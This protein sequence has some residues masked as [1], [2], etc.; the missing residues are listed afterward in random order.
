MEVIKIKLLNIKIL[1]LMIPFL[2]TE[3][4]AL[5]SPVADAV[6]NGDIALTKQLLKEGAEVNEAQGD[7]MT[8][9]HWAAEK[10]NSELVDI[11]IYAGA[12]PMAGTRIGQYKPLHL[13]AKK[14]NANIIKILLNT[15]ID[16]NIKT[17]NS[18]SA[19]L[20]LAAASGNIESVISLI[21]AGAQINIRENAR[22]IW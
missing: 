19:A 9:L 8:A 21:L 7:G 11:L 4:H 20:H 5:E 22:I 18:G 6:E 17:S 16:P 2:L 3:V 13:A 14:G 1:L 15:G 10:G 12:N